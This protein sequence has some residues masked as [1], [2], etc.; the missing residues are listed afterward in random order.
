MKAFSSHSLT[1]LKQGVWSYE[2]IW[3]V[4]WNFRKARGELDW[5]LCTCTHTHTWT[6]AGYG[7]LGRSKCRNAK[8]K[9]KYTA[10][11]AV[12]L[13]LHFAF[14]VACILPISP[15]CMNKNYITEQKKTDSVRY[16]HINS[17]Y[18]VK[19][20]TEKRSMEK[21]ST[22]KTATVKTSTRKIGPR[23]IGPSIFQWCGK[24]VHLT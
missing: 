15:A 10:D 6:Q 24:N 12:Y 3:Q 22:E 20:T 4:L 19:T 18:S 14:P 9:R 7:I 5:K 8:W 17:R 11:R 13:H 1:F 16:C 21:W 2:L 23:K